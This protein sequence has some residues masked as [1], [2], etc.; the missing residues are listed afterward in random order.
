LL[1]VFFALG[2]Q[3]M[4]SF[5]DLPTPMEFIFF[6]SSKNPK[7]HSNK[8]VFITKPLKKSSQINI[9]LA[10]ELQKVGHT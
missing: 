9:M 10:N 1:K 7:T 8:N 5:I 2:F 6:F 4:L 3:G